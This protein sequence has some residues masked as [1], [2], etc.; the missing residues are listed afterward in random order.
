MVC[1]LSATEHDFYAMPLPFVVYSW[2]KIA[3]R[4]IVFI[5][6]RK[7]NLKIEL[8]IKYCRE[9]ASDLVQFYEFECEEKRVPTFSQVSRLFGATTINY[10]PHRTK[11]ENDNEVMITGDSD[12]A[13]FD[14]NIFRELNDGN[15]HVIGADL[16]PDEQYPM[17]FAAMPV[18]V[19]KKVM[20][21]NKGYQEHIADIVNPIEGENV[22]GTNWCLDQFL[23]KKHI[24]GSG[25][26]VRKHMRANPGTQFASKRADRD[27]WHFD[28][29]DII[30]AHLPR[31]LTDEENFNKVFDLFTYK[32]PNDN[33]EWMK[34]Y[35][36]EYMAL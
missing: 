27:G 36:N 16:T 26:E 31:P 3:V 9:H 21:I 32:Y 7:N 23:L 28:P 2:M 8:A 35:R 33:L 1:V 6:Q 5:P 14:V 18:H 15:I 22:R 11:E 19:W 20:G 24:D 30:D 25:L 4:C 29:N 12:L 34:Q 13:V 17:C 10:R